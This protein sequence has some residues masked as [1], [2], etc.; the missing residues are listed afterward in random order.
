IGHR[1]ASCPSLLQW[2]KMSDA[3]RRSPLA[4][5]SIWP[6]DVYLS[7]L[8]PQVYRLKRLSAQ[9]YSATPPTGVYQA[10]MQHTAPAQAQRRLTAC[11]CRGATETASLAY[12]PCPFLGT[13]SAT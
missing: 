9:V 13:L 7:V 1:M 4:V 5:E 8:P 2:L 10:R 11:S 3:A 6:C 12:H